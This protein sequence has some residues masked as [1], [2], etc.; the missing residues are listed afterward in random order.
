MTPFT[1]GELL[2]IW[3]VLAGSLGAQH[4]LVHRVSQAIDQTPPETGKEAPDHEQTNPPG[5]RPM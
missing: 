3:A 4:P 5:V 2:A 1:R